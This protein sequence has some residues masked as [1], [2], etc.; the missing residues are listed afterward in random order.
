MS[1]NIRK[2]ASAAKKIA[3]DENHRKIVEQGMRPL[4]EGMIMNGFQKISTERK[5]FDV[6]QGNMKNMGAYPFNFVSWGRKRHMP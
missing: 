1:E 5:Y 3:F 2:F 6:L 4:M